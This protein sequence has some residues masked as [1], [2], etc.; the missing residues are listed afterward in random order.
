[1]KIRNEP[2]QL[3]PTIASNLV[4]PKGRRPE[5]SAF[6]RNSGKCRLFT[7]LESE[8]A[9]LRPGSPANTPVFSSH[10]SN[11]RSA[12]SHC[13]RCRSFRSRIF[14][15]S[16]W[17]QIKC[18]IGRLKILRVGMRH[19]MR[20]RSK[21][22]DRGG[23]TGSLPATNAAACMPAISPVAMDSTYP[24][25]PQICPANKTR[26]CSFICSVSLSSAGELM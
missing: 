5:E 7:T 26:G 11:S 16:G 6:C 15:S 10:P 19:I 1:M 2:T 23:A 22:L 17:Q 3:R 18:N 20:Q 9:K 13:T 12:S 21:A 14:Y 25:T 4:I 8:E 24:S